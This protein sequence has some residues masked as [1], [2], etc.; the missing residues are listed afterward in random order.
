LCI[1]A[2]FVKKTKEGEKSKEPIE[3]IFIHQVK[4]EQSCSVLLKF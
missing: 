1:E 3:K 2:I 4:L